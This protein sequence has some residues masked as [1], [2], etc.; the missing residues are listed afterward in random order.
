ME[1]FEELQNRV[2]QRHKRKEEAKRKGLSVFIEN[3][4][5]VRRDKQRA[6]EKRR[7]EIRILAAQQHN[8]KIEAREIS[9][10]ISLHEKE[11]QR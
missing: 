2:E 11:M 4:R 3:L 9:R 8:E 10:Q 1:T 7:W 6:I 5:T